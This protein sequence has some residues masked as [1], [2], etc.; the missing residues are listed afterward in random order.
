MELM[1]GKNTLSDYYVTRKRPG[2]VLDKLALTLSWTGVE[3][4]LKKSL[5]ANDE[6]ASGRKFYPAI[7]MFKI[8]LL[9]TWYNLSDEAMEDNLYD[10][11]SFRLFSG[12]S[13]EDEL[14]DHTTICRFRN[15]LAKKKIHKKLLD[16]INNQLSKQGK[17]VKQGVAVDASIVASA[18]RPRT[19]EVL[20]AMPK[21]REEDEQ[22]YTVQKTHSHDTNAAWIKKGKKSYYGYKV[23]ASV[24]STD[25]FFLTGH[26]TPANR[27]DCKEFERVVKESSM[28]KKSRV[29]ADKAYTSQAHTELLQAKGLKNGIMQKSYR[30]KKLSEKGVLR[31][32]LISKKRYVVERG[33]GSMKL[34][35]DFSRASYIGTKKVEAEFLLIAMAHNIKRSLR[36]PARERRR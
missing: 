32:K 3:K 20:D 1:K 15:R 36:V 4:M 10:R 27:S 7:I 35:Y 2:N 33:F 25:G 16:E 6:V 34:H 18:A 28:P 13:L 22:T 8:L 11:V 26:V 30:N 9:Q 21:D 5:K 23:H 14:P 17:L 31:N 29:Y 24:D 12:L 19:E